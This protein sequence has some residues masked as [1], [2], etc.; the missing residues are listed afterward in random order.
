MLFTEY[1][2][3]GPMLDS[4]QVSIIF[5][6]RKAGTSVLLY[7]WGA[8][9]QRWKHTVAQGT[10]PSQLQARAEGR[11]WTP[12]YGPRTCALSPP[13]QQKHFQYICL[14]NK[15]LYEARCR[16]ESNVQESLTYSQLLGLKKRGCQWHL[17][18]QQS[19]WSSGRW[20][21]K[22]RG[23]EFG[24]PALPCSSSTAKGLKNNLEHLMELKSHWTPEH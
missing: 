6:T 12:F 13:P 17:P 11:C 18:W 1:L 8:E 3:W 9:V 20:E 10:A 21:E 4:W 15:T 24:L 22:H 19:C 2:F 7:S 23:T 5:T 16:Q 14:I